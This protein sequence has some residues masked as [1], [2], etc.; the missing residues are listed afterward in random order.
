LTQRK[1]QLKIPVGA[2][3]E[4]AGKNRIDVTLPDCRLEISVTK[5]G[6]YQNRL[7]Q[8]MAAFLAGGKPM[9]VLSDYSLPWYFYVL[10]ALPVGIPIIT[11]GGAIP[12]AI[13]FGLA[14]ACFGICQQED[15]PTP[16]RLLVAGALVVLGYAALF[17]VLA[18]AVASKGP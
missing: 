8:D 3:A 2:H 18:A 12:G 9:P 13:G 10:S 11:L 17:A 5:F 16:V 4:Y 1:T 15:W 14:A 7:A 6:S